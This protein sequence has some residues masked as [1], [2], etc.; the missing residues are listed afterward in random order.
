MSH[1]ARASEDP[2]VVIIDEMNRANIPKVFG[3]LMY[4]LEYRDE[5]INL[6]YTEAFELPAACTSSA[7]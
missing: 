6:L 3:E 1:T 5:P 2:H 4:L 7:L